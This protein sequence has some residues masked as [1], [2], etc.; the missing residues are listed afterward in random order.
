MPRQAWGFE[1][2]RASRWEGEAAG[3]PTAAWGFG[4]LHRAC[5][6][7]WGARGLSDGG[8]LGGIFIACLSAGPGVIA[9]PRM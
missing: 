6:H 7:C 8:R 4:L 3:A 9:I 1:H 2:P 5:G